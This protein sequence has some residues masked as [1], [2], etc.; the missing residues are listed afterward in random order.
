MSIRIVLVDDHKL[1]RKGLAELIKQKMGMDVVGEAEDGI[2]AIR[3]AFKLKP[4]VVC[5]DVSMPDLNGIEATRQIL[6]DSPKAAVLGLSMHADSQ[7]VTEM[8]RAGAKGYMLKDSAEKEFI[9]AIKTVS[10]GCT[11]L[12]PQITGVVVDSHIRRHAED[13]ENDSAYSILSNREREVLQL[14]AEGYATKGVAEKIGRSVKTAESHRRNIMQKLKLHS[15]AELTKYAIRQ[16]IT[17]V[18]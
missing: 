9:H 14:L 5:M 15:V 10:D 17:D 11:Y 16:G 18:S 2:T 7:Y 3:M 6:R 4:D 1:L 13:G 8:L 12:S